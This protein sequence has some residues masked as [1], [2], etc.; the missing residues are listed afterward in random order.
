[1]LKPVA[2]LWLGRSACLT[3][4]AALGTSTLSGEAGTTTSKTDGV[5]LAVDTV[6]GRILGTYMVFVC[7][8]GGRVRVCRKIVE[9]SGEHLSDVGSFQ[10]RRGHPHKLDARCCEGVLD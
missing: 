10:C 2:T 4:S 6:T 7:A 5:E 3:V 1:M 9:A 8:H